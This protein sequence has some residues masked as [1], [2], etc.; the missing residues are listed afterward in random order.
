ME[1]N[2]N[3]FSRSLGWVIVTGIA[4]LAVGFALG[5]QTA[6]LRHSQGLSAPVANSDSLFQDCLQRARALAIR[7][8]DSA[9]Q[10]SL[11]RS[12]FIQI[13]NQLSLRDLEFKQ[14]TV[15]IAQEQSLRINLMTRAIL[16]IAATLGMVLS[17]LQLLWSFR[18]MSKGYEQIGTDTQLVLRF[19]SI[20]FRSSVVGVIVFAIA[21]LCLALL[22]FHAF[23]VSEIVPPPTP[24]VQ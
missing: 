1:R 18:L 21:M 24:I 7:A 11:T 13:S 9:E 3:L 16:L 23:R 12:C 19:N 20:A 22:I 2:R 10:A 14:Q 8:A 4:S 17:G 6:G 15:S 5:F